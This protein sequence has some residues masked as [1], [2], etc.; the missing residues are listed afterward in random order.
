[1]LG[2]GPCLATCG[3]ILL[4]YIAA[5][6]Q[7]PSGGLRSWLV[8]SLSR[9]AVYVGLG[10]LASLIGTGLFNRYYWELTGY[11]I[12]IAGGVFICFLG[13]LIFIGRDSGS[14]LCARLNEGFIQRDRKSLAT[15]GILVGILPCVPLMGVL[16][17]I[18]MISTRLSDGIFMSAAFSLGTLV[19][20]LIFLGAL[21]G[22]I[23]RLRSLQQEKNI[24]IYHRV[25]AIIL[26]ILGLHIIIRTVMSYS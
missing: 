21:V 4:S 15:L 13:V 3:P 20:P 12:W 7:S 11:I 22:L 17:Y 6:K 16:S 24:I 23:P 14:K 25:C 5:T 2:A 10:F 8:F 9:S 18:T 19:S 26:I 1:M